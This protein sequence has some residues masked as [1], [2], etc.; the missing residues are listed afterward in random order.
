M[1]SFFADK[2][3]GS[4]DPAAA[5]AKL[6]RMAVACNESLCGNLELDAYK[7]IDDSAL[8][9]NIRKWLREQKASQSNTAQV[10][11]PRSLSLLVSLSLVSLLLPRLHSR[12]LALALALALSL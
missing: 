1:Q 10:S 2:I 6:G 7:E 3:K 8:R 5:V 4:G 12:S 11:R 9:A